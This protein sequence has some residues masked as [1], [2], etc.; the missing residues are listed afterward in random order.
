MQHNRKAVVIGAGLGGLAV[1]LRLAHHGWS[2]TVCERHTTAGGKMNRWT[3]AGYTFDTGP[4]LITMPW[5]FDE[6][7]RAFGARREDDI[8]WV[9]LHPHAEYRYPDGTRFTYSTYLPDWLPMVRSL[10]GGDASGFFR[11]MALGARL[12]ELSKATFFRA[13]P[14]FSRPDLESLRALRFMPPRNGFGNYHRVV[15]RYFRSTHLRQLF[16]RYTTYVGSSPY[17]TPSTLSVIPYIEYAFGGWHVRGGLYR[18]IEALLRHADR[19]GVEVRTGCEVAQLDYRDGRVGAVHLASGETLDA[20]AVIMNGDPSMAPV[21]LREPGARPL[22]E[23]ERSLS[24]LVLLLAIKNKLD[25]VQHHTVCFS[26]DYRNEFA[27]LF[28]ERRFPDDPTVYVNVPTCTD[29]SMA[30]AEGEAVFVMA[31]APAGETTW[32]DTT[33][34]AARRR[35]MTR[36]AA[37][38][39]PA[40]EDNVLAERVITP[41]VLARTL[42][43]PGGAI[44]GGVSHGWRGAFMRPANKDP[45]RPGLYYVGGGTHPGGGTPTV[46]LSAA[47]TAQLVERYEGA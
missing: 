3:H 39:F 6:L 44:Y 37:S 5:V 34:A 17:H 7:W 38:E 47:I 23:S 29:R 19:L 21:L 18:I 35:I 22:P 1:A 43:M 13:H 31:N 45:R 27:Q 42:A 26:G 14:R 25:A 11:F 2:V 46:L 24:G 28:D 12:Y 41:D 8:E 15:E 30:P 36:L 32:D 9:Q 20:D 40:L 10:E 4:S 33:V 16:D